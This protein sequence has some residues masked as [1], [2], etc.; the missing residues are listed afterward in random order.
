[1]FYNKSGA[2]CLGGGNGPAIGD[3]NDLGSV[4]TQSRYSLLT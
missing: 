3:W 2:N 4:A 1:M